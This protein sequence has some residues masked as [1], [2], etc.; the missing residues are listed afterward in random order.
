MGGLKKFSLR[1]QDAWHD[2]SG[3]YYSVLEREEDGS[4]VL[5]FLV[6]NEVFRIK[7]G[8]KEN[9]F[10]SKLNET[11]IEKLNNWEFDEN[12][13]DGDNWTLYIIYDD[14]DIVVKGHCTMPREFRAVLTYL[15]E[16]WHLPKCSYARRWFSNGCHKKTRYGQ[17][18]KIDESW[19]VNNREDFLRNYIRE[20]NLIEMAEN[21]KYF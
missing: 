7:I 20:Y 13:E 9:E 8:D 1:W 10:I 14:K 4:A 2:Y 5:C 21:P 16:E 15:F 18:K 11:C 3:G 19:R 17:R 12:C 6:N